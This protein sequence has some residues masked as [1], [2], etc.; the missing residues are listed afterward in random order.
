MRDVLKNIKYEYDEEH[1]TSRLT[2]PR[3][4]LPLRIVNNPNGDIY[5]FDYGT[6]KIIEENGNNQVGVIN[7][8]DSVVYL[9]FYYDDW[10]LHPKKGIR[11]MHG[12]IHPTEA[13]INSQ[14]FFYKKKSPPPSGSELLNF[15]QRAQSSQRIL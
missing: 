7:I 3:G 14:I 11:N 6:K 9:D 10:Q 1:D 12:F 15:S 2:M 8:W 4:I 13:L 5:Y